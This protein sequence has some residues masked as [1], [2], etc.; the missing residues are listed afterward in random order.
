MGFLWQKLSILKKNCKRK[1]IV[2]NSLFLKKSE[3]FFLKKSP[4][5]LQSAHN[6]KWCLRFSTSTFWTYPNLAKYTYGWLPL[7]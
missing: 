3:Y 2:N 1:N 6:I 7:E 5:P 4:T